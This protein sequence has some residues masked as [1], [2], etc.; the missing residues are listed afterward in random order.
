MPELKLYTVAQ[1]RDWL[2][3]N[4]AVEGLTNEVIR[5]AL[6]WAIIHHPHVKDDDPIVV[7]IYD[8]G[9]LAASTCAY[10]EKLINPIQKRIWWFPMLW[11]KPEYRG[12]AYGLI[13]VGSLAEIYG[14]DNSWTAWAVP[15]TI[16]IFD[17]L[18]LKTHYI[19]R[20]FFKDKKID[21]GNI[22]GRLVY[23]KQKIQKYIRSIRLPKLPHEDFE[24]R[25]MNYCDDEMYQFICAHRD[26]HLI[27][28]SQE[29]INW[30]IQY[31]WN[32]ASPLKE[33]VHKDGEFFS[34]ITPVVQYYLVQVRNQG[35]IVGIY[36]LRKGENGLICDNLFYD[37]QFSGVVFASI[38]EHIQEWKISSF[39]TEDS[40]LAAYIRK[41]VFYPVYREEQISLS[42][43]SNIEVPEKFSR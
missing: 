27:Q 15:E 9:V 31:P 20:Y 42:I 8:E 19:S 28:S 34:E 12:K 11:V 29:V 24:L 41:Y 10:P 2:E 13:V 35:K 23:F 25:Y 16:E 37:S 18:G 33:R 38:V 36:R 3:H 43:S 26:A 40:A 1:V 4:I 39:D 21:T 17:Y 14:A 22:R 5:P 7:A 30:N 6:A 32:T